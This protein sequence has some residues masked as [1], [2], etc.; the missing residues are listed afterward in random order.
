M[1]IKKLKSVK[2]AKKNCIFV[3]CLRGKTDSRK[4]GLGIELVCCKQVQTI[5]WH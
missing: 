4:I 2:N 1:S 3:W 5:G